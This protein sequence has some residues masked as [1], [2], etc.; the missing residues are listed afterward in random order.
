MT[1]TFLCFYNARLVDATTDS[2]GML[3]VEGNRIKT[4]ALGEFSLQEATDVAKN[5][6]PAAEIDYINCQGKVLQPAFIDLHAHF[7]YPG[8]GQKEE[9]TT[10]LAAAVAGGFGTLVLMPNTAPVISSPELVAR[11]TN[12]PL[13]VV[14]ELATQL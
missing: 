13:E 14:E 12:L 11:C 7:R 5:L 3:L 6:L 9:L 10:A 8:Q 4:V 2:P 1:E